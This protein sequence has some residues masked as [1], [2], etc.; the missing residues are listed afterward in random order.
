[1]FTSSEMLTPAELGWDPY[2]ES[3]WQQSSPDE[4][5]ARVAAEYRGEYVVWTSRGEGVAR[6]SGRF[7][8]ESGDDVAVA[9]GDWVALDAAP[10]RDRVAL[11]LRT[12]PR[13]TVISRGAAGRETRE[14]VIAA[15]V[16][17]V[18]VVCGLDGDF[19]IHRIQR[20]L[21]LV[22]AGGAEPVV[23]L[24]KRD[25]CDDV[26]DR[27]SRVEAACPGATARTISALCDVGLEDLRAHIEPGRTVALV[28]SSGAGKS[29]LVNALVG[30]E[31]MATS[32]VREHDQRGRHTT[33]HRQMIVLPGGGL[34]IDTP[35]LRE[36]QLT[37]DDGLDVA[38][39]D[40]AEL[41][42]ECRFA[43]CR[44]ETEP[45]CAVR[46]AIER[47][48]LDADRFDH[49][50][51]LDREA[52]AYERRH[53]VRAARQAERAWGKMTRGGDAARRIKRGE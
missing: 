20:Y 43:D 8:H 34:L 33:T 44:H 24:S 12:L 28:G 13:R 1:M 53:D 38:F 50:V 27:V 16:D 26:Q 39:A 35:G 2:F 11:I 15:N 17:R 42:A 51:Q 52:K 3:L 21:A 47:G 5:P 18:F 41:A 40:I 32:E 36:L 23:V 14:Q 37:G 29:T 6:L 25:L 31:V 30:G 19:N 9:V 22:Y 49:Y 4:T 48:D 45:G 7:R 46:A 10:D